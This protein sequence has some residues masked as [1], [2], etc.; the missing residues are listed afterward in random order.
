MRP[1]YEPMLPAEFPEPVELPHARFLDLPEAR[2]EWDSYECPHEECEEHGV[3]VCGTCRYA[4]EP[5]DSVLTPGDVQLDTECVC[6]DCGLV[7]GEGPEE[8]PTG[9]FEEDAIACMV[10]NP[11]KPTPNEGQTST[12]GWCQLPRGHRRSHYYPHAYARE[13]GPDA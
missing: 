9:Y 10:M 7:Y 11:E 5:K 3:F 2:W 12:H 6:E 4:L 13:G 1:P 8:R